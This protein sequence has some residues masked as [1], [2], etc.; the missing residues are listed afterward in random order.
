MVQ[1]LDGSDQSDFLY[2][3][4]NIGRNSQDSV[5]KF[6]TTA[7]DLTG[8]EL[9]TFLA[10]EKAAAEGDEPGLAQEY[11]YLN[12]VLG[13]GQMET[14]MSAG[15]YAQDFNSFLNDFNAMNQDQRETFLSVADKAGEEV[16]G[17]L[18]GVASSLDASQ[19]ETF[20]AYADTLGKTSVNDLILASAQALGGGQRFETFGALLETAQ[21]LNVDETMDFLNA[22]AA[23]GKRLGSLIDI[24]NELSGFVKTEF[25]TVAD[26]IADL[27]GAQSVM[28]HFLTT[29]QGFLD[30]DSGYSEILKHGGHLREGAQPSDLI[31]NGTFTGGYETGFLK[32]T[33]FLTGIGISESRLHTWF[34]TWQNAQNNW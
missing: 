15:E 34:D 14:L 13:D 28:D 23:S 7:K 22:A 33:L 25:L 19:S 1:T 17:T 16:L 11:V 2:T 20:L 29:T 21:S 6:I 32:S 10:N 9:T 8:M 27:D 3:V 4:A 5:G 31:E 12:G 26:Y 24:T 30:G 18:M